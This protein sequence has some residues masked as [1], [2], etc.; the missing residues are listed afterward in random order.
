MYKTM[1]RTCVCVLALAV[2]TALVFTGCARKHV[3]SSPPAKQPAT[4]F[5]P[6]PKPKVVEDTPEPL[7]ENYVVDAPAEEAKPVPAVQEGDLDA[8]PVAEEAAEKAAEVEEAVVEA[9]PMAAMYYIQVG[10]FSDLDNANAVLA[11][12][13]SEGYKGSRLVK[14]D[15]G[16]YRVQAGAFA[17][18]DSAQSALDALQAVYPKGFILK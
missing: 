14:A 9:A 3:V 16:I 18:R 1:F 15:D 4:G 8:E 11:G 5:E 2:M 7:E 17:D 10:A 6:A 12:L 13:I